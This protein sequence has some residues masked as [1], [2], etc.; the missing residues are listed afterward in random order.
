MRLLVCSLLRRKLLL[1]FDVVIFAFAFA[2]V[3]GR[4]KKL[5]LLQ[6]L[7]LLLPLL[8]LMLLLLLRLLLLLLLLLRMRWIDCRRPLLLSTPFG[9]GSFVTRIRP[10]LIWGMNQCRT[11]LTI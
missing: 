7:L 5:L 10:L 8:L 11:R 6:L 4:G 9:I 1:L 3:V 2:F